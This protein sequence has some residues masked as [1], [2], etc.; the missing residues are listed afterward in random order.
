MAAR[1]RGLD[2]G[3]ANT[4]SRRATEGVDVQRGTDAKLAEVESGV[5]PA[6]AEL[7][8]V[9]VLLAADV[10]AAQPLWGIS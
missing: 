5:D 3:G 10:V 6:G 9:G 7:L 4:G 8:T 1:Q 2:G